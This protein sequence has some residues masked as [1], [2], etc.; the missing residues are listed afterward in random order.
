M[1]E[2]DDIRLNRLLATYRISVGAGDQAVGDMVRAAR[3]RAVNLGREIE[4]KGF[5]TAILS[6]L[7]FRRPARVV[8]SAVA[9][10]SLAL[11]VGVSLGISN[12]IPEA[13]E[14]AFTVDFDNVIGT[15]A[16][17]AS[18]DAAL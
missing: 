16:V 18:T 3:I 8:W 12:A 11:M 9:G 10:L 6:A 15:G 14:Q 5:G 7:G 17:S 4:D 1:Q 2:N 13:D